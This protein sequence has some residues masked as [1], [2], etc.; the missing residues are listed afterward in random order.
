V[1]GDE[2]VKELPVFLH[3]LTYVQTSGVPW[4]NSSTVRLI[5]THRQLGI[6]ICSDDKAPR[7]G[8]K[9]GRTSKSNDMV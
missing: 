4:S 1:L 5:S 2:H 7:F 8:K 9:T 6:T 3:G